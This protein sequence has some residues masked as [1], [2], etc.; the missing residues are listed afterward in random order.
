M[1]EQILTDYEVSDIGAERLW[2]FPYA[3][4]EDATPTVGNPAAVTSL[5]PGT[6]VTGVVKSLDAGRSLAVLDVTRSKIYK[7]TVRNVLT[8]N[9]GAENTFGAINIGDPV[10]YDGSG[11]MPAGTYLSTAP[12]DAAAAA[13]PLFGWV[14]PLD[15]TDTAA[16]GGATAS[17]QTCAV[18]KA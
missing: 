7:F 16:K 6:Q 11:T 8:Y 15:E 5:L 3:R 4:L 13:N 9:G 1:P 10:Y 17:T 18:M 14:V 12:A 2:P